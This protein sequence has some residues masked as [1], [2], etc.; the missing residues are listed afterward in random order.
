VPKTY[1]AS[2]ANN[3]RVAR[4]V[5]DL[6]QETVAAR[7][8]A[9]GFSAWVRQT[10]QRIEREKRRLVAEE[11]L[12]LALALE[13]SIYEL[14]KPEGELIQLPSG[15]SIPGV[16]LEGLI[17][18]LADDLVTWEGNKPIFHPG[19]VARTGIPDALQQF[20]SQIARPGGGQSR[21]S[22]GQP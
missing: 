13:T 12:G 17:C 14:L 16:D 2:L 1:A 15:E 21:R 9:L 20:F 6:D 3:A 22:E 8:R 7:M 4:V 19:S 5:K 10:V 11:V 18:G